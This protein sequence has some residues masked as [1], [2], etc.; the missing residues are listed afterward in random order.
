[1]IGKL[2]SIPY[3][4]IAKTVHG[5]M[6]KD[7]RRS[8]KQQHSDKPDEQNEEINEIE[9][10]K[11][12]LLN[13]INI[14]NTL[15]CYVRNGLKF[16]LSFSDSRPDV[17]RLIDKKGHILHEYH[18]LQFKDLYSQLRKDSNDGQKGTIVNVNC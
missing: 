17:V 12:E 5:D 4:Q 16:K 7:K 13:Y 9:I 1:M 8:S 11:E 2:L 15:E 6:E 18:P 3:Q 10:L 14:L